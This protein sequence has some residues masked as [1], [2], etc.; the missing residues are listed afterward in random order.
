MSQKIA[1]I[2]EYIAATIDFEKWEVS[3]NRF[4]ISVFG[5]EV[6]INRELLSCEDAFAIDGIPFPITVNEMTQLRHIIDC[7]TDLIKEN[8][9]MRHQSIIDD[10]HQQIIVK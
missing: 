5:H 10:F 8:T 9:R 7:V 1:D 2:V 6:S 3:H 4:S